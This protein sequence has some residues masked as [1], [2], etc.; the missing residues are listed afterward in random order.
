MTIFLD[1]FLLT[2][3]YELHHEK[4]CLRGFRPGL[5]PNFEFSKKDCT[6]YIVKTKALISCF[7]YCAADLRLY[8]CICQKQVF[9]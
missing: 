3:S 8:F 2:D 9:S 6:I 5:T 4:T 1:N 7:G